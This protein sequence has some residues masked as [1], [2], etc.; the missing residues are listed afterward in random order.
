MNIE[1]KYYDILRYRY[2]FKKYCVVERHLKKE[3][4]VEICKKV[5]YNI[6]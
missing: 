3:N 1:S 6:K 2:I 5:Q 4:M